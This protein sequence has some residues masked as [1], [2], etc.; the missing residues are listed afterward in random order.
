MYCLTKEVVYHHIFVLYV[1]TKMVA[2]L[3]HVYFSRFFSIA[4]RI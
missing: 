4:E 3:I 1:L 2:I